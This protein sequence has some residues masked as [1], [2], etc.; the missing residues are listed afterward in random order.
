MSKFEYFVMWCYLFSV[1]CENRAEKK[2]SI[3]KHNGDGDNSMKMK[4]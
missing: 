1:F 4:V 3:V 2:K